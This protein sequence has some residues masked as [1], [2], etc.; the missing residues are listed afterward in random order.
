M[1]ATKDFLKFRSYVRDLRLSLNEQY[2]LEYLF[3]FHNSRYG[4]AYPKFKKILEAF[5]ITSKNTISK[6]IKS[7]ENKGLIKVDRNYI[8][9]R[10]YV[11]GIEKFIVGMEVE[12]KKEPSKDNNLK[13]VDSNGNAPL[14]NQIHVK[15]IIEESEPNN[16][17]LIKSEFGAIKATQKERQVINQETTEIVLQAIREVKEQGITV[18]SLKYLIN[19]IKFMKN[20]ENVKK[21]NVSEVTPKNC[22]NLKFNNFE[23][24]Q[25]DYDLLEKIALGEAPEGLSYSDCLIRANIQGETM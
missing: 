12:E 5:N 8:N 7:L 25:Y 22:N 11:I 17:D 15:E 16:M 21:S 19:K 20:N 14:E 24:R 10:Y 18:T 3:E 4:Y 1:K 6:T 23:P 2:L 13:P 9:N